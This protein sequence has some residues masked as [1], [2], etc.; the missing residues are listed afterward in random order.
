MGHTRAP[1]EFVGKTTQRWLSG[2]STLQRKMNSTG[3]CT[4]RTTSH[5]YQWTWDWE[6]LSMMSMMLAKCM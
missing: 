6:Y 3:G 1:V 4:P 2:T 5:L